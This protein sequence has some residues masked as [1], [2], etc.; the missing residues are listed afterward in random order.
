[1]RMRKRMGIPDK[2]IDKTVYAVHYMIRK[3]PCYPDPFHE[4]QEMSL[5]DHMPLNRQDLLERL[6][7]RLEHNLD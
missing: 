1:M 5:S 2:M 4:E 7:E 3:I 6:F